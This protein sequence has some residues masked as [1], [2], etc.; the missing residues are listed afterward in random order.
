MQ[1]A[2]PPTVDPALPGA[3]LATGGTAEIFAL[4]ERRVLKLYWRGASAAAPERE[5]ERAWAAHAAG[6][7]SPAVLQ[8]VSAHDRFGVVF[9]RVKGQP[10][11]QAMLAEPQRAEALVRDLAR[12]HAQLHAHTCEA[13]PLQREHLGPRIALSPLN[14]RLRTAILAALARLPDADTLCHGDFHPGNVLLTSRGPCVIDWFDAVRGHPAA[15]VARTLLLLQY[16]RAPRDATLESVR[17]ELIGV[18]L[19][20]YRRVREMS[21]EALDAWTLP[22]A[23]A[24]LA[25]PIAGPERAT[26]LRLIEGML[27]TA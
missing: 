18:Y 9:E 19:D 23:A 4:D 27:A 13:L 7:P 8:V 16:A 11:L 3:P 26:L 5:A 12:L 15:D 14:H 22:V 20:E 2:A 17:K 21:A 10:M 6:A 25:E 24:R 1:A